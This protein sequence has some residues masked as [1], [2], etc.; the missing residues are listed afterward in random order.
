MNLVDHVRKHFLIQRNATSQV[1]L[2]LSKIWLDEVIQSIIRGE[3]TRAG[4]EEEKIELRHI[5][6]SLISLSHS[7][8][9]EWENLGSALLFMFFVPVFINWDLQQ[10]VSKIDA[11]LCRNLRHQTTIRA[12]KNAISCLSPIP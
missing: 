12:L 2:D 7:T 8:D 1:S 9:E 3:Q 10:A 11:T 5:M 4:Y 6:S